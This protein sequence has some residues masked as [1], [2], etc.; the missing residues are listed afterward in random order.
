MADRGGLWGLIDKAL[1][2]AIAARRIFVVN[3]LAGKRV[4]TPISLIAAAQNFTVGWVALGP[5]IQVDG[6]TRITLWLTLVI[7]NGADMR[8]RC[9]GRHTTG[10]TGYELPIYNPN[11]AGAPGTYNILVEGEYMEFNVD[12]NG[13]Y[14]LT[15]DV[16]NTLPF[17]YFEIE[18]GTVGAPTACQ[19]SVANVTYGWGS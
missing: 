14:S 16:S 17:V 5:E 19:V 13:V 18:A 9:M 4:T 8:V 3:D 6:F 2:L 7:N 12:A 11:V 15:W 10:G 1:D